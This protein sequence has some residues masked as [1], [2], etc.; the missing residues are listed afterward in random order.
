M[1]EIVPTLKDPTSAVLAALLEL[2]LAGR[3]ELSPGGLA[4]RI[5]QAQQMDGAGRRP[6]GVS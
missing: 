3:A 1:E 6:F 2:S 5:D 4:A